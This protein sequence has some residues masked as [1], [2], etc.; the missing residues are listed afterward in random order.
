MGDNFTETNEYIRRCLDILKEY[1]KFNEKYYDN[2]S[3]NTLLLPK[4]KRKEV[5]KNFWGKVISE[6]DDSVNVEN[7]K[8]KSVLY[9]KERCITLINLRHDNEF[10]T[11]EYGDLWDYS[12][13]IRW[14][15]KMLL[16]TNNQSDCIYSDAS[17]C[18]L[19]D[20]TLLFNKQGYTI[21]VMLKMSK[22]AD[23][24]SSTDSLLFHKI[25]RIIV[26][27]NFGKRLVNKFNIV[28]DEI[29]FNNESDIM[30]YEVIKEIINATI[31]DHYTN[32]VYKIFNGEFLD[33][34]LRRYKDNNLN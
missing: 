21:T 7:D 20:R 2:G 9:A 8:L 6:N 19:D 1:R 25:M 3:Y 5:K 14:C 13:F 10:N 28:D 34:K 18:S 27:R 26:E 23:F 29:K 15:E 11:I 32:I 4:E 16:Y 17:I 33:A 30:L 22:K 24:D 12:E 31:K